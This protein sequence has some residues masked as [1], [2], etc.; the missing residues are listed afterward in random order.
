MLMEQL[1]R[2]HLQTQRM[3]WGELLS[4]PAA[5]VTMLSAVPDPDIEDLDDTIDSV[6]P[7]R[8]PRWPARLLAFR[9][10]DAPARAA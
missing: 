8:P 3:I 1:V 5:L 2:Y 10:N 7:A 4:W 9:S 6:A